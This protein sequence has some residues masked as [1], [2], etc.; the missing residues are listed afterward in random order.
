MQQKGEPSEALI[1]SHLSEMERL[2]KIP[3]TNAEE[4]ELGEQ[5]CIDGNTAKRQRHPDYDRGYGA[6]YQLIAMKSRLI[7]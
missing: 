4:F 6:R 1:M 7:A 3:I 5:D 2:T